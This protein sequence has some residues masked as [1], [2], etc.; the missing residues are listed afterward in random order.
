VAIGA[1]SI[2][3]FVKLNAG[4]MY[5][6]RRFI[7]LIAKNSL[8]IYGVHALIIDIFKREQFRNYDTPILDIGF[9][10]LFTSLLSLVIA[11]CIKFFDRYRLV[12]WIL[13]SN[14]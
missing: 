7:D 13:L 2:F 8:A 6:I 4:K 1:C 5:L 10:F 12:T 3:V 9:V 14:Q 11:I